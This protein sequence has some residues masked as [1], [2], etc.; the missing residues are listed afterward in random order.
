MTDNQDE[1]QNNLLD[2]NLKDKG[3]DDE[4]S[5][6]VTLPPRG[7]LLKEQEELLKPLISSIE[8]MKAEATNASYSFEANT[9]EVI[10]SIQNTKQAINKV[11]DLINS[12]LKDLSENSNALKSTAKI[13]ALLPNKIDDRLAKLPHNFSQVLSDSIPDI[14]KKLNSTLEQSVEQLMQRLDESCKSTSIET[15]KS[16]TE[17][18]T[19]FKNEIGKLSQQ[20]KKDTLLYKTELEQIIEV[21]SKERMRKFLLILATA[22]SFSAIVS[23]VSSWVINKHFPRSVEITGNQHL[24]VKDSQVLVHGS[25]TYQLEKQK[26]EGK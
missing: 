17:L 10:T 16:T 3:L 23:G 7:L 13:L 1:D 4:I 9:Q 18:V 22:G 21:G 25:D 8:Q 11:I 24:V 15:E 20:F 6:K 12:P 14:A 2:T 26:K 5:N 19:I